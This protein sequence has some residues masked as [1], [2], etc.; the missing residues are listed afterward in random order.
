LYGGL[1]V[2]GSRKFFWTVLAIAGFAIFSYSKSS[3]TFKSDS[4]EKRGFQAPA[5]IA[6][7]NSSANDLVEVRL[8]DGP[9]EK[10]ECMDIYPKDHKVEGRSISAL[11]PAGINQ[12]GQI[13]G[14]CVL[15]NPLSNYPFIR[16]PDGRIRLFHTPG[17]SGQGEFTDINDSG[18]AVGFYQ[19][20]ASKTKV[21]FLMNATGKWAMDL[22]YPVN[23][24][25]NGNPYLQTQ[26]NGINQDGEIIGNYSCTAVPDE[27]IDGIFKGNGFYRAPDGTFFQLQYE[28]A[29]RTVAGKISN[30]GTIIGYYVADDSAW[31]PFAARKEDVLKAIIK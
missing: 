7:T 30:N 27:P 9:C 26:P 11:N 29:K 22:K 31:I 24:C 21:G 6:D 15:E 19:D 25:P 3:N 2:I 1:Q 4:F 13:V 10:I 20:A 17:P 12:Q 18:E 14:L 16:E 28:N 23:P 8:E 5:S